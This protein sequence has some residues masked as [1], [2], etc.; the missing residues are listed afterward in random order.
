MIEHKPKQ[1]TVIEDG[2]KKIIFSCS[3]GRT[4]PS[5][6]SLARHIGWDGIRKRKAAQIQATKDKSKGTVVKN[7]GTVVKKKDAVG[8][9]VDQLDS[10]PL[11][12]KFA[13]D[14]K[15][16]DKEQPKNGKTLKTKIKKSLVKSKS[17]GF[18]WLGICVLLGI[19]ALIVVFTIKKTKKSKENLPVGDKNDKRERTDNGGSDEPGREWT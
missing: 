8:H 5:K 12:V 19:I 3:C 4:F 10:A 7:K 14:K 13:D 2:K 1:K 9:I 15:Q 6:R 17:K 11:R 16:N 18:G